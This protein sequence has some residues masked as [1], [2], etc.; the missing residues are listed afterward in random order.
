M[1]YGVITSVLCKRVHAVWGDNQRTVAPGDRHF[2]LLLADAV[3]HFVSPHDH[4]RR[5]QERRSAQLLL[6]G[7]GI[8]SVC[9]LADASAGVGKHRAAFGQ[10][11]LAGTDVRA[12]RSEP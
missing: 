7:D 12:A 10:L 9:K 5:W 2:D 8:I 4:E 6:R 1:L 3:E 11:L